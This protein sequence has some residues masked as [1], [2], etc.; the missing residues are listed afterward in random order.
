MAEDTT[1]PPPYFRTAAGPP[2]LGFTLFGPEEL[3]EQLKKIQS[4]TDA[5]LAHLELEPMLDEMLRRIRSV[6]GTDTATVLLCA[7]DGETLEVRASLGIAEDIDSPI[8]LPLGLGIA[9]WVAVRREAVIVD[10]V[11]R[12]EVVNPLVR[13]LSSMVVAPLLA[14][15]KLLGVL[16]SGTLRPYRF[17]DWDLHLLRIVADRVA[18][19]IRN[20]LL[21]ERAQ[22]G[23]TERRESEERFRLLVEGVQDYA[24]FMLDP[25][26]H[27]ASWNTGA[28]RIKGYTEEEVLGKHFSLFYPGEARARAWPEYELEQAAA[29]GRFEDEGWRVRK[30]GSQFW[31][32]VVITPLYRGGELA[33]FATVTRDLTARREAEAALIESKERFRVFAETAADAIFT[34]DERSTILYANPA[35]QRIFG[36]SAEEL[37][38]Q[39]MTTLIPDRLRASHRAGVVRHAETG[40]KRIPWTGVQLPGL[41]KNGEEVPL[42]ISFGE[43]ERDGRHFYTGIARD[44][45]ERERDRRHL[46]ELAVELEATVRDLQLRT[47]EA[48][49]ANQAKTNFLAVM[50]HELR[51]PLT[52]VMGYSELLLTGVPEPV[53]EGAQWQIERID[54]AARHQLHLIEEILTFSR[55]QSGKAVVE[56]EEV[57]VAEVTLEAVSF[58]EPLVGKKGLRL[59]VQTPDEP[60]V[61]ISDREKIRRALTNILSNAQKF[62]REGEIRVR[63]RRGR[64]EV[65]VSIEDTGIGIGPGDIRKI[66]DPFWQVQQST[67]REAEGSGLGLTVALR[68]TE[69]LGGR[70][71]VESTPGSGSTFALHLPIHQLP[72]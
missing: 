5:A 8:P 39:P 52:A 26:G 11:S 61:L 54:L 13:K 34:V 17:S 71:T 15:G 45:T 44:I 10:D 28:G 35:V 69:V 50:S 16:H 60:L 67:I 51:T 30:D 29:A 24:I 66:F 27:V 22:H 7:A 14:E 2:E 64:T 41:M 47:E 68:I 56:R 42:E 70:I 4:V 49:A 62:T 23:G 1:V 37:L 3:A 55:L 9:G 43:Y 48:E 58:F 59:S 72:I 21:Y 33:G 6:L 20:A 65:V 38:G 53:P 63:V 32:N 12:V 18:L 57:D 19:A 36:Y 46:E 31:S 25:E 40:E